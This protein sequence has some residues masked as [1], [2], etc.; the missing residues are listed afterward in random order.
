MLLLYPGLHNSM[1][2]KAF[3]D[4]KSALCTTPLLIYPNP[5]LLYTVASDASRDAATGVLMQDQGEGLRSSAFMSGAFKPTKQWYSAYERELAAIAY[6]FIQWHH[7]LE[8]CPRVVTVVIDH[9][10][11]TTTHG[12]TS[13]FPVTNM[14]DSAWPLPIDSAKN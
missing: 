6:C 4:L 7:Y 9:K 14:L 12:P 5:S 8:G 1:Q 3:I 13:A 10:P 11:L 2:R